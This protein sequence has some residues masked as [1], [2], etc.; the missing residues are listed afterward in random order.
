MLENYNN[1]IVQKKVRKAYIVIKDTKIYI[2]GGFC[3]L[4]QLP[5]P[6]WPVKQDRHTQNYPPGAVDGSVA[7]TSRDRS[8][9][10]A[11]CEDL[12]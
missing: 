1:V 7:S 11:M 5:W 3:Q 8:S 9:E 4:F 6:V 2:H 10:L 12:T